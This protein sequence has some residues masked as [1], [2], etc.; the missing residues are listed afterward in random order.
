MIISRIYRSVQFRALS[1]LRPAIGEFIAR[2]ARGIIHVGANCGQEAKA[3]SRQS[4]IW[5]E[6]IPDVYDQLRKNIARYHRQKAIN[7]LI[8]DTDGNRQVLN[9]AS[10]GGAS[11]SIFEFDLHPDI[12]PDIHYCEKIEL[13]CVT[14]PTALQGINLANYDTLVIDVQGAE[15][16]VLKGAE[17]ILKR[18]RMIQVEAADFSSYKN[19]ATS[20]QIEAFLTDRGY[21]LDRR[22]VVATHQNGGCYFELLF[23]RD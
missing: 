22:E 3:Y 8:G 11:S 18:F 9:I 4:V 20:E 21:R 23:R 2:K 16:N 13:E 6:P 19:G 15:L 7:A 5:I 12:W 14:L 17:H 10:N 1:F